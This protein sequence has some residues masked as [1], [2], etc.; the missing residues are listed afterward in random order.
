MMGTLFKSCLMTAAVGAAFV[1]TATSAA[2]V[3]YYN[4]GNAPGRCQ[5]FT[6]GPT[7]TVRNRVSGSENIGAAMNVACAF[8]NV[9]SAEGGSYSTSAGI[10]LYNNS[11]SNTFSVNCSE[12][13]G[14]L[15]DAGTVLSKTSE[16]MAPGG[17]ATVEFSADDTAD[18]SDTDLGSFDVG[19][20]CNLPT[21]AAM[22]DTWA[23]WTDEDGMGV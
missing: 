18:V 15:G 14:Y 7:N 2:V 9:S 12:L 21:N 1:A 8:E 16:S 13:S 11:S 17:S 22:T 20:V 19:V 3:T 23:T 10:S 4:E 6:P 5:A